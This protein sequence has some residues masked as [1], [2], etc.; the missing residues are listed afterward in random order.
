MSEWLRKLLFVAFC[1]YGSICYAQGQQALINDVRRE[2]GEPDSTTEG[3]KNAEI[4]MW[5]NMYLRE[6]SLRGLYQKMDTLRLGVANQDT[7]SRLPLD[8]LWPFWIQKTIHGTRTRVFLEPMDSTPPNFIE[9]TDT[10]V[11]DPGTMF[12]VLSRDVSGVRSI[13]KR[14]SLKRRLVP[15]LLMRSD[16]EY[17][18]TVLPETKRLRLE[19]NAGQ[20]TVKL[21]SDFGNMVS[22]FKKLTGGKRGAVS[23]IA[24]ESASLAY[25]RQV[26][27]SFLFERVD[28]VTR[29]ATKPEVAMK[30]D[31]YAVISGYRKEGST[32]EI[33]PLIRVTPD[34]L[35]KIGTNK[36]IYYYFVGQPSPRINF[37]QAGSIYDTAYFEVLAILPRYFASNSYDSM[38]VLNLFPPPIATD[39]LFI[40]YNPLQ[41]KAVFLGQP[42]PRLAHFPQIGIQD[43]LYVQSVVEVPRYTIFDSTSSDPGLGIKK[44]YL[45]LSPPPVKTDTLWIYYA[46]LMDTMKTNIANINDSIN[47]PLFFTEKST[48]SAAI[49][50]VAERWYTKL[51]MPE[52]AKDYALKW[53]AILNEYIA[54]KRR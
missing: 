23:P 22:I 5:L 16:S 45:L 49:F 14:D 2:I 41:T 30:G 42:F 4:R 26:P 7:L 44:K 28:T 47:I 35:T 9:R 3:I 10:V 29:S 36:S 51:F 20:D 53:Q 19:V 6:A 32:K 27:Q 38:H 48:R 15:V 25:L 8:F 24:P 43:T 37:A 17:I 21:P 31:V 13:F 46:A 40:S 50:Y 52:R 34:S 18:P 54:K 12:S 11:V 1:A 33:F 39:T